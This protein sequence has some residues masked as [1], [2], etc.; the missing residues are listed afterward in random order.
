[1]YMLNKKNCFRSLYREFLV[2]IWIKRTR[3]KVI[4]V[5]IHIQSIL[6]FER[7]LVS[8]GVFRIEKVGACIVNT[9]VSNFHGTTIIMLLLIII[10]FCHTLSHT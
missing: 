4:M 5:Q 3:K 8:R 1:M 9:L 10:S 7:V 6:P 2:R